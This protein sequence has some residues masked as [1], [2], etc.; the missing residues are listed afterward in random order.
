MAIIISFWWFDDSSH[1]ITIEFLK[2]KGRAAQ[3]VKDYLAKLKSHNRKPKAIHLDGSKEFLNVSRW[4]QEN[5]IEVQ[6]TAPYSPSQNSVAKHMNWTLV[7]IACAMIQGLPEYLWE[8]AISHA[9]YLCNHIGTKSLKQ[10]TLYEKWFKKKPN[11]SHLWE[12]RAPVWVLLQGQKKPRKMETKSQRRVFVG[13]DD[14][15][16]SIK[17]YNVETCKVLTSRNI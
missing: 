3:K 1:Y 6:T 17:Y 14:G 2:D 4:C 10:Q 12:F 13:F 16:K 5:S 7:E 9:S 11:I 8:Y 15:S